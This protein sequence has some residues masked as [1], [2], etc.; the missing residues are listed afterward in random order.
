MIPKSVLL[1]VLVLFEATFKDFE[2]DEVC[3][4]MEDDCVGLCSEEDGV[5]QDLFMASHVLFSLFEG[6]GE[7]K[8]ADDS[9]CFASSIWSRLKDVEE[10]EVDNDFEGVAVSM[11]S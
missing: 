11:P 3:E 4:G 9:V 10:T 7:L 1:I 5:E 8:V 2:G 6:V